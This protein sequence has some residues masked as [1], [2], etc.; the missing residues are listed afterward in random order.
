ML[1]SKA[2]GLVAAVVEGAPCRTHRSRL[3][4]LVRRQSFL[5]LAQAL[6]LLLYLSAQCGR[7]RSCR[8][9]GRR[10]RLGRRG[11]LGECRGQGK[12][13]RGKV[14][15]FAARAERAV[16]RFRQ[17]RIAPIVSSLLRRTTN[18]PRLLLAQAHAPRALA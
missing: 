8:R 12:Q 3:R 13:E 17:L 7:A 2:F 15:P 10:R 18:S 14:T 6:L 16:G 11:R 9:I 1:P 5:Q 4:R